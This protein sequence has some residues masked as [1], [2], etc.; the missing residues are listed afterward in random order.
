MSCEV[1]GATTMRSAQSADTLQIAQCCRLD[2]GDLFWVEI[3]RSH[4]AL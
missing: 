4:S 3:K 1:A 2:S